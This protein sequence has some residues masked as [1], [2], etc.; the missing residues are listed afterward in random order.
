[1]DTYEEFGFLETRDT[2]KPR[3]KKRKDEDEKK[4]KSRKEPTRK[5]TTKKKET[6]KKEQPK[7]KSVKEEPKKKTS[8]SS[9]SSKKSKSHSHS[10]SHSHSM[11][12]SEDSKKSKSSSH[13]K[14][15]SFS[16]VPSTKTKSTSHSKS[17]KSSKGS[18]HEASESNDLISEDDILKQDK[19]AEFKDIAGTDDFIY[20]ILGGGQYKLVRL[21][22][23]KMFRATSILQALKV[24]D[25]KPTDFLKNI[26]IKKIVQ[27]FIKKTGLA[28][29]KVYK[30][31]TVNNN[32]F[33]GPYIHQYLVSYFVRLFKPDEVDMI[34]YY[35]NSYYTRT[36][37]Q[38]C[39]RIY[40]MKDK[41][42]KQ[43]EQIKRLFNQPR[44]YAIN[45]GSR[46]SSESMGSEGSTPII[47]A[48]VCQPDE[49]CIKIYQEG[50]IQFIS[51]S[52]GVQ[53]KGCALRFHAFYNNGVDYTSIM[54]Q[55]NLLSKQGRR[56]YG[57]T[58]IATVYNYLTQTVKPKRVLVDEIG[59]ELFEAQDM[60]T[61]PT[62]DADESMSASESGSGSSS[63]ASPPPSPKKRKPQPVKSKGKAKQ[64]SIT[65]SS[66]SSESEAITISSE[67]ESE[68][69][70]E[71][72]SSES[73][74]LSSSE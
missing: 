7:K 52:N 28:K 18:K 62:I 48:R 27:D 8:S 25:K 15:K 40:E 17:S 41:L 60:I 24:R 61:Q 2:K 33:D 14:H 5:E 34:S 74:G 50:S 56:M 70:S 37:A 59:P 51:Q 12:E 16:E 65:I 31:V 36:V 46:S 72:Q 19:F 11:S 32:N 3:T 54:R 45:M 43:E 35:L 30:V 39:G 23:E 55:M 47:N 21:K 44:N 26:T 58:D 67:T 10:R 63:E 71:T 64:K 57:I 42:D 13:S 66:E 53:L 49:R 6:S 73:L 1:M 38:Y 68:Q 69:S 4:S 20:V 29:E 9:H 22:N